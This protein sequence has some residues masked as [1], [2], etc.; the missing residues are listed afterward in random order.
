MATT[1]S[2]SAGFLEKVLLNK[3]LFVCGILSSLLYVLANVFVPMQYPGY[4]VASQTVS[5]LSALDTPTRQLWVQLLSVY[6]LLVV[7]FG[8]GLWRSSAK[9]ERLRT[10]GILIALYAVVGVFWPPMHPREV[11]AAGGGTLTD[12]LH[13][14]FTIVTVPLMLLVIGFAAASFGKVFRI[15]SI[16]AVATIIAFGVLTGLDSPRMEANLP[17]PWMGVWERISI[18]A[19]MMWV[20]VLAIILLRTTRGRQ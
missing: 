3:L 13:I 20:V 5:E 8:W 14:V 10:A 2:R 17:T 18:G 6:S 4:S 1:I 9:D 12:T 15:Y 16:L 7:S 11:L 19:Y